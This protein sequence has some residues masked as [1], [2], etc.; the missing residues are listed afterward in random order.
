QIQELAPVLAA[1]SVTNLVTVQS[2]SDVSVAAMVKQHNKATYLFAVAMRNQATKCTFKFAGAN[3]DTHV[4]VLGEA[5]TLSL[6]SGQFSDEFQPYGVHLYRVA[7][8]KE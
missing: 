4:E 2:A 8:I 6:S 7:S 1:P 3:K 5:R